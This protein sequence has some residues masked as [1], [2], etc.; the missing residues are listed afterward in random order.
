MTQWL[1]FSA[2]TAPRHGHVEDLSAATKRAIKEM[3]EE[4]VLVEKDMKELMS[5]PDG[6]AK[7]R[8]DVFE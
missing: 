1:L 7:A 2:V 3:K 4:G 6:S 5:D 8:P